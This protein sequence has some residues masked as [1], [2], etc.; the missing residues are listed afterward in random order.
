MIAAAGIPR[1]AGEHKAA[2]RKAPRAAPET[3]PARALRHAM[4][5]QN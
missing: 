2:L 5:C 1:N 3:T 4:M